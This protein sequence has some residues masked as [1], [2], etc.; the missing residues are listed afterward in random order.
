MV[1]EE[2]SGFALVEDVELEKSPLAANEMPGKEDEE[3]EVTEGK[4]IRENCGNLVGNRDSVGF[5]EE[6]G[7]LG[8]A[9]D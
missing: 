2:T 7:L 5:L 9:K 3:A 8:I 4:E 6:F 1:V